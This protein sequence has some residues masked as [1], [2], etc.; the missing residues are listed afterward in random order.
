MGKQRA[1]ELQFPSGG[2]HRRF[3][4]QKQPPYT[5]PD[6]L[7]VWPDSSLSGRT[8]GGSRPGL[9]K[10]FALQLGSGNPVR[11]LHEMRVQRNDG[12]RIWVDTFP[13]NALSGAWSTAA[14]VSDPPG[15]TG[16]DFADIEYN[17]T[18]AA[19][20]DALN[21][22]IKAATPYQVSIYI[23]P[24]HGAHCGT[25]RIF[26]HMN[27]T[28]PVVTTDG[29]SFELALTSAGS[30][31][32]TITAYNA[33]TPSVTDGTLTADAA[34]SEGGWLRALVNGTAVS[35]YWKG[36]LVGSKTVSLGAGAGT[37][38]GFGMTCDTAGTVAL[39]DSFEVQYYS[40]S[41]EYYTR[42]LLVASAG[43][44]LYRETFAG[45]LELV[46]SDSTLRSDVQLQAAE[47]GGKLYIADHGDVVA[48]NTDGTID[49]TGLIFDATSYA[50]WDQDVDLHDHVVVI[51]HG[52]GSVQDGIYPIQS[53]GTGAITL[54]RS[55]GG[56]GTCAYSIERCP[57]V[58]DPIEN[59]LG[60]YQA[61]VD[62][63]W[64]PVGYHCIVRYMDRIV[65]GGQDG[66]FMSRAGDPYDFD[67]EDPEYT[68]YDRA[69]SAVTCLA[70]Q[71][72]GPIVGIC[73]HSDQYL[74]FGLQ[75]EV[76]RLTGNPT[77]GGALDRKSDE[78]GFFGP[79]SWCVLPDTTILF[80]TRN[81]GLY[82]IHP[83][84][85]GYATSVST[86]KLPNDLRKADPADFTITLCSDTRFGGVHV[87]VTPNEYSS[88]LHWFIEPKTGAFFP[89][90]YATA[91]EPTTACVYTSTS[92]ERSAVLLGG[93]DG[94]VRRH[95]KAQGADDGGTAIAAYA[96]IGPLPISGEHA[97]GI[98]AELRG[99]LE[100][101]S[102]NVAWSV[103]AA[104]YAEAAATAS[105]FASGTWVAGVNFNRQ[106]NA[107]GN[108]WVLKVASP[109]GSKRAWS[110]VTA[111]AVLETAGARFV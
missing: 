51:T 90:T 54:A 63:G 11:L 69:I 55:A 45:T 10:A 110:F 21:P 72:P 100:E 58:Y 42:N 105:A 102:G 3:A 44:L 83:G 67:L 33:S 84:G 101:G 12:Y 38:I 94:Y 41:V 81:A 64:I 109:S 14:W 25:F 35:L 65:F 107:R 73:Q 26:T 77:S 98:V 43:G 93:R 19:V 75:N 57:K 60:L 50:A 89:C 9:E 28:T 104:K 52:T 18:V 24:Y 86:E 108:A 53:V 7:N 16:E 68:D 103:H 82:M 78:A 46:A 92:A 23:A 36:T 59:T 27:G 15:V 31:T 70:G 97:D 47:W 20:R 111:S 71:L 34:G 99:I 4:F 17:E 96:K 48:A 66:W 106:P 80:Y 30:Y 62:Q 13:G 22:A 85:E 76:W 8:S 32:A 56:S 87:F 5:T 29:V 49:A 74:I 88:L 95:N 61:T 79:L 6:C 91:H 37:R 40:S 1:I 39:V 2:L